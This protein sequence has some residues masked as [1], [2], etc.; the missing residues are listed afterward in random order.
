VLFLALAAPVALTSNTEKLK[1]NKIS[2]T[3]K[4]GISKVNNLVASIQFI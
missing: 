2:S 4:E 3:S 1:R